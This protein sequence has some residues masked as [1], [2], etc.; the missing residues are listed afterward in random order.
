MDSLLGRAVDEIDTLLDV[1]LEVLV[2]GLKEGLLVV[3][4]L[5]DHVDGILSTRGL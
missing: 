2:A 5:A 4:G 1:A 3:V